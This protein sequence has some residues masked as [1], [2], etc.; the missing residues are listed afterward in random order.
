[1]GLVLG[2]LTLTNCTNDI[3]EGLKPDAQT[4]EFALTVAA[5][6][7]TR[8]TID[9]FTTSWAAGDQINLFYAEPDTKKYVNS[10]N[11]TI[12]AANLASNTFTG[13]VPVEFDEAANYDWYAVYPYNASLTTPANSTATIVVGQTAQTQQG[14]SS[15]AH[16]CGA[17]A[18]L[19]GK[20][21]NANVP[22][23]TMNHLVA[24]MELNVTNASREAITIQSIK[25]ESEQNIAGE[26]AVYFGGDVV[27]YGDKGNASKSATLTVNGASALAAGAKGQYYLSV[28]PFTANAGETITFTITTDK[29]DIVIS[30]PL[31]NDLTLNAGKVKK[32]GLQA[33]TLMTTIVRDWTAE[34]HGSWQ[35]VVENKA[36]N[37]WT[38]QAVGDASWVDV[39]Y[40]DNM[41]Y[42]GAQP[43]KNPN[44][45]ERTAQFYVVDEDGSVLHLLIIKQAGLTPKMNQSD[46]EFLYA[47][48]KEGW[49]TYDDGSRFKIFRD[50]QPDTEA[51][52]TCDFD[53]WI[54]GH[55]GIKVEKIDGISYITELS[56]PWGEVTPDGEDESVKKSIVLHGFPE[57]MHL[58]KL[59]RFHF[60]GYNTLSGQTLPQ[61]WYTPEL[62]KFN[63]QWSYM[64][65][66][67]PAGLAAT[68]KLKYIRAY[69]CDF[70]GALPHNWESD[71]LICVDFAENKDLG[72]MV[73]AS[74]DV[75]TPENFVALDYINAPTFRLAAWQY[76]KWVGFEEGWGQARCAEDQTNVAEWYNN[77]MV[78]YAI[79]NESNK[80]NV[81]GTEVNWGETYN[82]D[83]HL[84]HV[85]NEWNQIEADAYTAQCRVNRGLK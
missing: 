58:P 26:Y 83:G 20:V 36:S 19:V 2:A 57:K 42:F 40:D 41:N 38:V 31:V 75:V 16:L 65:G 21:S 6:D 53:G 51:F 69:N 70:Y 81:N 72:Y 13:S 59:R 45:W 33:S 1:M 49:L 85:M 39:W 50:Y 10:N 12:S 22:A 73:P 56:H 8:T 9:D 77:R 67:I 82:L 62:E 61:D 32:I 71:Q 3:N 43:K 47:L 74:L 48:I 80:V 46:L 25:V 66:E 17:N 15:T 63:V 23:I 11:F 64:T 76:A 4:K 55:S 28:K 24:V 54:D 29:G 35:I 68:P 44:A 60:D 27:V 18:P 84:P 14:N 52:S 30:K 37:N 7:N 5:G 34:S 79:K 78:N